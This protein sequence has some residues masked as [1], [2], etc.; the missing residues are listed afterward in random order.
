MALSRK[1]IIL[2]AAGVALIPTGFLLKAHGSDHADTPAIAA[3]PGADLTDVFVFPSPSDSS[4]VVLAMDVHPLIPSGGS[5]GVSFDPSV[6]YQFKIDN[7]GDNVEDLVIQARFIG[8]GSSQR[9]L[10]SGPMK[11]DRT[12]TVTTALAP[13]AV[14]GAINQAFSPATG[15]EVFAGAREDPFFFD[16]NRF[17]TILPDRATP[18]TGTAVSNPNQPQA[19]SFNN[20]GTDFLAPYNVLAIVV[21]LPKTS[22]VPGTNKKIHVWCTTSK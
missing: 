8:T 9:V 21:E 13:Y 19:A 4:K 18:I 12:G 5:G 22:L 7:T 17:F 2:L 16:L 6:L 20:P 1:N 15:I 10:I 11:P 14:T 3:Q